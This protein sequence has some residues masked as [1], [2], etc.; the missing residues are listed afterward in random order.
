MF[1]QAIFLWVW[2]EH[3]WVFLLNAPFGMLS[4]CIMHF[5]QISTSH[6]L[7]LP[8]YPCL[9]FAWHRIPRAL[10]GACEILHLFL[11]RLIFQM[12]ISRI[13]RVLF[14][15][16][17]MHQNGLLRNSKAEESGSLT[18]SKR[19]SGG[20][21]C[22]P[23]QQ[24]SQNLVE[25]NPIMNAMKMFLTLWPNVIATAKA[26]LEAELA[27]EQCKADWKALAHFV[28]KVCLIV[29]LILYIAIIVMFSHPSWYWPTSWIPTYSLFRVVADVHC[30]CTCTVYM[31]LLEHFQ[32]SKVYPRIYWP[33][34]IS[35]HVVLIGH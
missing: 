17:Q 24:I 32:T 21:P 19:K 5:I 10:Y 14:E 22:N 7:S 34:Q 25:L 11:W 16:K 23:K 6:T 1:Y 18:A 26:E 9:I 2:V 20:P 33:S 31:Y 28:E 4:K 27:K 13:I 30:I 35:N 3:W 12:L 15:E 29:F 8:V